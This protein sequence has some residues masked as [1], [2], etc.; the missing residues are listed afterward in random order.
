MGWSVFFRFLDV[1]FLHKFIFL[2]LQVWSSADVPASS[3]Q[4]GP[5][6]SVPGVW[7]LQEALPQEQEIMC[8]EK[9]IL[10]FLIPVVILSEMEQIINFRTKVHNC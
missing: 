4:P 7:T 1:I 3:V 6:F 10:S 8:L 5:M 2:W 9:F